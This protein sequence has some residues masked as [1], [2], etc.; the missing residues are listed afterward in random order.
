MRGHYLA[1]SFWYNA[2]LKEAVNTFALPSI[3][4]PRRAL[5]QEIVERCLEQLRR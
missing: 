2:R 1:R 3:E 5:A 4:L